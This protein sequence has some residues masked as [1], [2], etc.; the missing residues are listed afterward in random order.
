[1]TRNHV[2]AWVRAARGHVRRGLA[3]P[4]G[5]NV[6]RRG[7]VGVHLLSGPR[8][9]HA[10]AP[11]LHGRGDARPAGQLHAPVLAALPGHLR[12]PGRVRQG[13]RRGVLQRGARPGHRDADDHQRRQDLHLHAAQGHQVLQ[14]QAGHGERRRWRPSSGSSRWLNP[15]AG[16]WYNSIVGGNAC[17]AKPATCTLAGGVVVNAATNQVVFHLVAPDPEFLDQLAVPL[18]LDPAGR[19]PGQGRGH[20]ADPRHGGLRVLLVQPEP[21]S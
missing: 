7:A 13:G 2:K 10:Q 11:G 4:H 6:G 1:M 5:H 20:D 14:R 16:S 3:R 21:P 19:R 18:R 17:L 8:R 9:G 15:N 12:R